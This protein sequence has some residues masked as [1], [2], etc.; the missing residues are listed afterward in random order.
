MLHAWRCP[1]CRFI[2]AIKIV[3]GS[4]LKE[5]IQHRI[6]TT[7]PSFIPLCSIGQW[8][9]KEFG[10]SCFCSFIS[11]GSFKPKLHSRQIGWSQPVPEGKVQRKATL[12]F[13]DSALRE[14]MY[15]GLERG[16]W[17]PSCSGVLDSVGRQDRWERKGQH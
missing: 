3:H 15:S 6:H 9:E 10:L 12:C 5:G 17:E 16:G 14:G 1:R 4:N 13:L 11:S 7:S 8:N 2:G